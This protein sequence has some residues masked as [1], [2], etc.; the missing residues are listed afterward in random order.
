MIKA[1]L[2]DMDGTLVNTL[3]DLAGAVNHAFARYGLAPRPVENFKAYAGSGTQAMLERALGDETAPAPI[4]EILE[5]Y[6]AYYHDHYCDRTR[7]YPG[8]TETVEALYA[9]GLKLGVVTNKIQYMSEQLAER[10]FPGRFLTVQGQRDPYPTK[11]DRA[12]PDMAAD[13][14]GV[15]PGECLFVGDSDI[16]VLT[17]HNFGAKAAGALWGFR[18]R[19]ELAARGAEYLI[20]DPREILQIVEGE[21]HVCKG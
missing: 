5:L 8:V 20:A 14:L 19:E 21:N 9:Q 2:F 6:R 1:V 18:T 12:L 3:E 4:A 10:F 17:A 7:P 15:R 16:D 11:P 13:A